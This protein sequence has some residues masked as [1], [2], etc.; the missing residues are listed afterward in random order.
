MNTPE[1]KKSFEKQGLDVQTNTPEQYAAFIRSE[2][3]QN[4]KLARMAGVKPE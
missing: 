2:I 3:E 4:S 1:M